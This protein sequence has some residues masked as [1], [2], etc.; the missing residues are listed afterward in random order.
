MRARLLIG[1]GFAAGY[2]LGARAGRARY[3]A[4]LGTVRRLKD[5]PSLQGTAGLLQAQVAGAVVTT[6]RVIGGTVAGVGGHASG[7]GNPPTGE[8]R[9]DPGPPTRTGSGGNR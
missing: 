8:P 1:A 5:D 9:S 6:K 7:A 3:D 2:V 4:I